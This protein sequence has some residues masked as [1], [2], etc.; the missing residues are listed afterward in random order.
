MRLRPLLV[1][2]FAVHRPSVALTLAVLG[3]SRPR[4]SAG[5][6]AV[7][8]S[9]SATA[10]ASTAASVPSSEPTSPRVYSRRP[11][12]A[13]AARAKGFAFAFPGEPAGMTT[14]GNYNVGECKTNADCT[15]KP[16]GQCFRYA[17]Q[18]PHGYSPP[19]ECK[20][21]A[22]RADA[23]CGPGAL[24]ACGGEAHPNAC[25]F[26][27]C[28]SDEDCGTHVACRP[29]YRADFR[30]GPAGWFCETPEDQCGGPNAC[31]RPDMSRC[32]FT[33]KR[34]ECAASPPIPPG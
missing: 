21:D 3:C 18:P 19:S 12:Q 1:R 15:K 30:S 32:A 20:Y 31:P 34:W 22:C 9:G 14:E 7:S 6:A 28:V 27:D 5:D 33:G 23:D 2:C 24:C 13:C 29:S 10:S 4:A 8:P 17:R 16:A 25:R 11:R 26:G